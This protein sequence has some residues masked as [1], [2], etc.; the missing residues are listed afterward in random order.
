MHKLNFTVFLYV[1]NVIITGGECVGI[2]SLK[3]ELSRCFAMKYLGVLRY[4]LGIEVACSLKRLSP[5]LVIKYI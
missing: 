3:S 1:D 2:E 4:C 5:I